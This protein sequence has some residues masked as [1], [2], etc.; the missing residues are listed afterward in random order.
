VKVG[1]TAVA[2]ST[3]SRTAADCS[4]AAWSWPSGSS[5]GPSGTSRSLLTFNRT[6]LVTSTDSFGQ[7]ASSSAK[8]GAAVCTC[9]K[10]ST[11][12]SAHK[13]PQRLPKSP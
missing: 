8:S 9:S 5:S 11:T 6:R 10:L 2:R 3:K 4:M 7:A 13:G 12:A 1:R